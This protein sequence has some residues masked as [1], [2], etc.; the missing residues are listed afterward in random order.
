MAPE[1]GVTMEDV[2]YDNDGGD[3]Y[4]LTLMEIIISEL[5]L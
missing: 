4:L 1:G 2:Q 5:E 3:T